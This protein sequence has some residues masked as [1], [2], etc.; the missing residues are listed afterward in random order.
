MPPEILRGETATSASDVFSLG[1][2]L[3]ELAAG[4]HPFAGDTPLD[5]FE[6]IESRA[7]A[8]VGSVREGFPPEVDRLI[9]R[10]LDRDPAGRPS[11]R[12]ACEALG[13]VEKKGPASV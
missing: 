13:G 8:P 7:L 11:A 4:Q 10:M 5:V 9:L 2:F 3:Y 1:S 12:E 6:A